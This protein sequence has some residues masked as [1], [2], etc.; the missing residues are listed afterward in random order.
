MGIKRRERK[1]FL[2]VGWWPH[3]QTEETGW[4]VWGLGRREEPP[5]SFSD[6]WNLRYWKDCQEGGRQRAGIAR[7]THGLCE[8]GKVQPSSWWMWPRPGVPP[9]AI[10]GSMDVEVSPWPLLPWEGLLK[11]LDG[12]FLREKGDKRE[13]RTTDCIGGDTRVGAGIGERG[14]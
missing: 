9:A 6:K 3:C 14:C 4:G 1:L 12:D 7:P 2:G 13:G 8:I 10:P 11:H 5:S